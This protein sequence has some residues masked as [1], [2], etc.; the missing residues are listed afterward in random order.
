M[1]EAS[2]NFGDA[3]PQAVDCMV[4]FFYFWDYEVIPLMSGGIV[5]Q[6]LSYKEDADDSST[7][8]NLVILE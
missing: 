7:A 3:D 1:I 8:D 6:N 5:N 2:F 4:R